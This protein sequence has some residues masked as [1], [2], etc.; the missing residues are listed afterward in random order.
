MYVLHHF[1]DTASL[2]LR[3]VLRELDQPFDEH[4]IDR[5]AGALDSAAYRA[6]HPMGKIPAMET[7]DGPMFETAAM[8]LY[9]SDCHPGLAPK[10][11]ASDRAAFL[12]WFFFTSTYVH[13]TLMQ[14][15]YPEREA[16]PENTDAVRSHASARMRS[17][18]TML[19]TMMAQDTPAWLS[20]RNPTI[21][22]YY[23]AVLI[24]WLASYGPGHPSYFRSS[25]F[26]AL[27]RVLTYLETRPAALAVAEDESLGPT[28][29]TAP[30]Y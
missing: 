22:G 10:P 9:L 30:A 27:H 7:P 24:R 23:L 28:I 25:E 29:F 8:L 18:L 2:I 1:P 20:D 5:A 11:D 19:D 4:L 21:F 6:L 17:Y 26:P 12:K 13:P 16:G 3:L 15:F 14:L